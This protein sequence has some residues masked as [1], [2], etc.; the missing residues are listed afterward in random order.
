MHE[1]TERQRT[2]TIAK[3]DPYI[4]STALF[5]QYDKVQPRYLS[6]MLI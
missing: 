6:S 1:R 5:K 3:N 2:Y 4:I